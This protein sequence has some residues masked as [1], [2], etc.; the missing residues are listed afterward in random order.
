MKKNSLKQRLYDE[1]IMI[2]NWESVGKCTP[3]E[4][5]DTPMKIEHLGMT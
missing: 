1:K 4:M 5:V 3:V 2:R